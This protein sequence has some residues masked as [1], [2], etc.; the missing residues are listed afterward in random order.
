MSVANQSKLN[1]AQPPPDTAQGRLQQQTP[2][3]A[4]P[5]PCVHLGHPN[6]TDAFPPPCVHLGHPN[7][8]PQNKRNVCVC[9][10]MYYAGQSGSRVYTNLVLSLLPSLPLPLPLIKNAHFE[11]EF[12]NAPLVKAVN[13]RL[14]LIQYSHGLHSSAPAAATRL[15]TCTNT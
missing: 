6:T 3:D 10:T 13:T 14:E 9:S 4:F 7:T 2:P 5:P 8:I 15:S 11:Q 1:P 12:L